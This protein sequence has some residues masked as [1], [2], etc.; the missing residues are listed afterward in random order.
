MNE[1][2]VARV[3]GS[4]GARAGWPVASDRA[5]A[6]RPDAVRSEAAQAAQPPSVAQRQTDVPVEVAGVPRPRDATNDATFARS[7]ARFEINDK[8]RRLSIKI[9]D[10]ATD[11]VIREIPSEEVQRIAEEL[12]ALARRGTIGKR[13]AGDV[14]ARSTG[15]GVDR[16]V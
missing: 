11:E 9:V 7:Y 10:A 13:P 6:P 12:Q 4:D 1:Q 15:G 8:T 2:T 16:Y 14:R 5:E 3:I